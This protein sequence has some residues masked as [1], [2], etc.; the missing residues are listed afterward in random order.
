MSMAGRAKHGNQSGKAA[1]SQKKLLQFNAPGT[2]GT[3]HHRL[4]AAALCCTA[5]PDGCL[6]SSPAAMYTSSMNLMLAMQ[7][8][9]SSAMVLRVLAAPL[10][11]QGSEGRGRERGGTRG[12]KVGARSKGE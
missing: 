9:A 8:S 2:L 11:M 6:G 5:T 1:F 12:G 4:I 7:S 3:S 10:S